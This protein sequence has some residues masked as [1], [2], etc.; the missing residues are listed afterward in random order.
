MDIRGGD[1]EGGY[2]DQ[3][4]ISTGYGDKMVLW[5]WGGVP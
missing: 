5:R 3:K 4:E 2:V 1:E